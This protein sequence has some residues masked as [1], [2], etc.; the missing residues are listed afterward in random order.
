MKK[1]KIFLVMIAVM[2]VSLTTL[3]VVH[4][5][6]KLPCIAYSIECDKASISGIV[7]AA[8]TQEAIQKVWDAAAILCK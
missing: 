1:I 5:K 7:C 4:A 2:A 8:T 6:E 3:Y